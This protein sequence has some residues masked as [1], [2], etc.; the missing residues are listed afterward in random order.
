MT[1]SFC[2]YIGEVKG[3]FE[4]G[5]KILFYDKPNGK[6]LI[7]SSRSSKTLYDIQN[8][9]F[10]NNFV[11]MDSFRLNKV[12]IIKVIKKRNPQRSEV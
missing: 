12:K 6:I 11:T 4:K 1:R 2:F 7:K 10:D 5:D 3:Q 8:V 9:D